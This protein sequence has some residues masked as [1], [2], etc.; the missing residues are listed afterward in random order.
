M[1]KEY[2]ICSRCVMDT[3]DPNIQFDENGVCNHCHTYD[4]RVDRRVFTGNE[5][6]RRLNEIVSNIKKEGKSN[7][8]DCIVGLSGGV[9]STFV[10]LKVK[11]L[12]L[13]P[14]AIHLD[15]GWNSEISENNIAK[16]VKKLDV[17]IETHS[18]NWE[19]F[20]DLQISFLKASTPD[21]EIP[22]DHA[23]SALTYHLALQKGINYVI[24]GVNA[25]TEN[26]LPSAWSH[27][28]FD[29]GYIKSIHRQF[30]RTKLTNYPHINFFHSAK[31]LRKVKWIHILDYLDYVKKDSMQILEQQIGWKYYGGKH[32]E[33]IYT[34]FVQ[35]YILPRKFGYDKRKSHLSSLIC[36]G[37]IAREEA[38]A[39]LKNEPYPLKMQEEDRDYVMKKL[40]INSKEFER[41]MDLPKKTFWDY[42]SYERFRK[43]TFY[44]FFEKLIYKL[45]QLT[46]INYNHK[47]AAHN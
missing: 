8:Y 36:S 7:K 39:E 46:S 30:G 11:E 33:S 24:T 31:W 9:D 18:V 35:G 29:W 34:R 21:S 10:L 27:G 37:E 13:R 32:Y 5:G 6:K 12:G 23:I 44:R 41:I 28:H 19:E 43:G 25:R 14:L 40:G 47:R 22:T 15:N 2:A 17:D 38:I 3:T 16:A 4:R 42:P 45:R 1:N 20:K 26:H